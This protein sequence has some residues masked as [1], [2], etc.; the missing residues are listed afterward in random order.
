MCLSV[1][2]PSALEHS[3]ALVM[4][5]CHS[6]NMLRILEFPL[7]LSLS[8]LQSNVV[9]DSLDTQHYIVPTDGGVL[10][11]DKEIVVQVVQIV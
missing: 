11:M 2:L 7:F 1:A 9:L 8:F 6:Y 5:W 3:V 10:V 4:R